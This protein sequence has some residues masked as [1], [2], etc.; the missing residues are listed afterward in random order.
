MTI[1][2]RALVWDNH[3][4]MPLRPDDERFVPELRRLRD[5]GVDVVGLTSASGQSVEEH[6]RMLAISG[7]G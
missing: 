6:L 1:L 5:A 7:A 3:T 2:D 4:C